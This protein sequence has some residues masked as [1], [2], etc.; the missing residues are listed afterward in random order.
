MLRRDE[1]ASG[2]ST[3]P[4]KPRALVL[5]PT[6]ELA[7]QV[8]AT[9][10][11]YSIAPLS[12]HPPPPPPPPPLEG[13]EGRQGVV[14]FRPFPVHY[15]Q[16]GRQNA[17]AAGGPQLHGGH[18]GGDTWQT[19]RALQGGE[20]VLRRRALCGEHLG[21]GEH[22]KGVSR[23]LSDE[24]PSEWQILDEADTMF[25]KGFG[26]DVRKLLNPLRTRSTQAEYQTL[27]VT[28]TITKVPHSTTLPPPSHPLCVSCPPAVGAAVIGRRVS[29][30][31][32]PLHLL[33]A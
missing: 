19:G 28:A 16:R 33:S 24:A 8:M 20:P 26:P 3:R 22:N 25:D 1:E 27:L 4:K 30:N 14:P 6:R 17:A 5:C 10:G 23:C 7:E 18:R 9:G 2:R 31:P 32:P 11:R 15:D 13:L 12:T 29:G 21:A